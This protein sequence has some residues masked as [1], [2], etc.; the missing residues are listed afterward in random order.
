MKM[1]CQHDD[2]RIIYAITLYYAISTMRLVVNY[3][4]RCTSDNELYAPFHRSNF[5][6]TSY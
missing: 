2:M 1:L 5:P 4:V 6:M 3:F